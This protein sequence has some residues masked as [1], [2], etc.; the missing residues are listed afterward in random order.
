MSRPADEAVD[1]SSAE[2]ELGDASVGPA[3]VVTN[4]VSSPSQTCNDTNPATSTMAAVTSSAE[5]R[6]RLGPPSV[7]VADPPAAAF[8]MSSA[9]R[10]PG[11]SANSSRRST[12]RLRSFTGVPPGRRVARS[13]RKPRE[14]RARE[15]SAVMSSNSAPSSCVSRSTRW[16]YST[17]RCPAAPPSARRGPTGGDRGRSRYRPRSG[18]ASIGPCS[19]FDRRTRP[20][21]SLVWLE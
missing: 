5:D 12:S 10:P 1:P 16:R 11:G 17:A 19:S 7:A 18:C 13:R 21:G 8:K 20:L 15:A 9:A 14:S 2:A 6:R 3:G 4:L